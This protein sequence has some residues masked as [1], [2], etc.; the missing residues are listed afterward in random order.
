MARTTST[1]T[2]TVNE[3]L[4]EKLEPP[5][6]PAAPLHVTLDAPESASE[7]EPE[8]ASEEDDVTVPSA[9]EVIVKV[10]EVLSMLSVTLVVAEFPAASVTVPV[11]I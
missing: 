3:M 1:L 6:V 5:S 8:T 4:Q 9:G 2:P 7:I 10:G 11:T